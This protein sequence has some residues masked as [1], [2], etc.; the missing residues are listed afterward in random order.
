MRTE[1]RFLLEQIRKHP[2][3]ITIIAIGPERNLAAAIERDAAT[4]RKVKRVV[5][6]GG[7]IDRGYDGDHGERRPPDAEWNINRDPRRR[8]RWWRRACRSF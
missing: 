8:R 1:S 4:F 3:E 6:M 5:L 7:S 2:G